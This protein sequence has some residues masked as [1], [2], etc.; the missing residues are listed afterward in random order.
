ME[1][2]RIGF[3]IFDAPGRK[4]PEVATGGLVYV[5]FH[6]SSQIYS[7]CYT[8]E[9]LDQWAERIRDLARGR[10]AVHVYFNN[11]AEAFAVYNAIDLAKRL[12]DLE[13]R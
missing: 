6:G 12:R 7:S 4:C 8:E 13:Q 1:R 5:R 11:D 3:C 10:R 9:E 2:Q